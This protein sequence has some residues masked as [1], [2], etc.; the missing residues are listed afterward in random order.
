MKHADAVVEIWD[1]DKV[2]PYPAN[3]K[4]HST[5]QVKKLATAIRKFGWTS[6]IIVDKKGVI[7]A[8]HGRR[9]AAIELGLKRVPVIPRKDLTEAEA[10]ALRLADNRV[11]STEYDQAAIQ[12]ELK[13][14][15]DALGTEDFDLTDLGFDMK[16]IDFSLANLG[17]IEE[18]F[19]VD[20]VAGA[21]AKQQEENEESIAKTDE[22]AAPVGDALGFKRIS[23]GESRQIR[24]LMSDIGAKTGKSGPEML[25]EALQTYLGASA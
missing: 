23:I 24:S 25:I 8:G 19:F 7:I 9:L 15:A 1:I 20:D 21:V 5:E 16:E 13:R 3:A 4:I 12:D 10:D 11:S 18:G 22:T 6:P 17:E 2:K 14:L